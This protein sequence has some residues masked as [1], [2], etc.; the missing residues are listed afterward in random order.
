MDESDRRNTDIA[1]TPSLSNEGPWFFDCTMPVNA[2]HWETIH[3]LTIVQLVRKEELH[4]VYW[5]VA[6]VIA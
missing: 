4:S 6:T 5:P 2:T 1:T 3:M